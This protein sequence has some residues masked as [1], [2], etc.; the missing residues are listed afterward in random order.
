M[1]SMDYLYRSA[2]YELNV[3]ETQ[4]YVIAHVKTDKT[5]GRLSGMGNYPIWWFLNCLGSIDQVG[6]GVNWES[7]TPQTF[8]GLLRINRIT[9]L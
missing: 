7:E 9:N 1:Y 4:T 6:Q 8:Q 5:C 2:H 3:C